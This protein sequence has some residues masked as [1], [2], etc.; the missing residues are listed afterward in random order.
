MLYDLWSAVGR[1]G[2]RRV[3]ARACSDRVADAVDHTILGTLVPLGEKD[4][5]GAWRCV[6]TKEMLNYVRMRPEA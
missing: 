1:V 5:G 4:L 2:E 3:V 6:V